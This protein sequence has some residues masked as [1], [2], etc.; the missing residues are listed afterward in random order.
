LRSLLV[1]ATGNEGVSIRLMRGCSMV[2]VA[3]FAP[4]LPPSK[5]Y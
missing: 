1:K 3:I 5:S 4:S 2:V